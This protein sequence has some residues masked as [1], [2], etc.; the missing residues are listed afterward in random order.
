MSGPEPIVASSGGDS[1]EPWIESGETSVLANDQRGAAQTTKPRPSDIG[2]MTQK[3]KF[4]CCAKQ[5]E[6][7]FN[8][9]NARREHQFKITLG[10]WALLLLTTQFLLTKPQIHPNIYVCVAIAVLIVG[11]HT[12][13]VC[14]IWL[15]K[16]YDEQ[17]FF[18]FRRK[19][20]ELVAGRMYD[21]VDDLPQ[22]LTFRS[23]LRTVQDGSSL[24]QIATTTL[25]TAA[26]AVTILT[27]QK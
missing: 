17:T 7:A 15:K 9:F 12:S 10:L 22:H 6:L 8:S 2:G 24:F 3:E 14:G 11:I 1:G 25:L 13:F 18:Y 19:C 5:A 21:S 20:A 27:V 23:S 16:V 4:D 26:C